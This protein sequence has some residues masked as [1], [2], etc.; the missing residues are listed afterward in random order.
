LPIPLT[1]L[2]LAPLLSRF[3]SA[4]RLRRRNTLNL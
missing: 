1:L 2:D 4:L 3:I